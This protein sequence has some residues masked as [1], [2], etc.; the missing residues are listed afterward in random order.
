MNKIVKTIIV[1]LILFVSVTILL[2]SYYVYQLS[3]T[4]NNKDN[5]TVEI[6]KGSTGNSVAGILKNKGLIKDATIF[7]LYLKIHNVNMINYG[8]YELNKAM[9][10]EKI[11][12]IISTGDTSDT[13]IKILFKEGLNIRAIAKTIAQNTNNKE[14][15]VYAVLEDEAYI[16]TLI[17]EY[18]FIDETIKNKDI[19]YPLEGYLAPNTYRFA[20]KNVSIKDIFKKML[21]QMDKVLIP[22][23]DMMKKYSV[24]Q[25][26]TLASIVE[27]EGKS[28]DDRKNIASVFYNR[29][30]TNDKLGSDV[31][32]YYGLKLDNYVRNL[33][34]K[35]IN[36]YNQYNTRG[37]YMM[38][39]LPIGP[40]CSPSEDAI[41]SVINPYS[42]D[43]YYF[44]ADK[45]GKVYFT[46]TLTEH[47]NKIRELKDQKLWYEFE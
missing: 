41:E 46:K 5:I 27:A 23:K 40:I 12:D 2:F 22:Y 18:W 33:T 45:N 9:G 7:K 10:V 43:Y 37:P 14:E 21:D 17:D 30:K 3:P 13:D 16:D 31:T 38:G 11:V 44:V 42:N 47:N 39:K 25:Y 6:P 20:N 1:L 8:T 28:L 15:E 29:L 34:T 35:E 4:S 36:T 26:L 32:T 24:H 19:Y